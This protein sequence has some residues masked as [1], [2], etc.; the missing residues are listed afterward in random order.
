MGRSVQWTRMYH[1]QWSK[2]YVKESK[3]RHGAPTAREKKEEARCYGWHFSEG[4]TATRET[5]HE[6][7]GPGD[8]SS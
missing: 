5:A 4:R 8:G 3:A 7:E 6:K 1:Q 2:F